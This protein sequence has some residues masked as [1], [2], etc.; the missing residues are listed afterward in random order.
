M[1]QILVSSSYRSMVPSVPEEASERPHAATSAVPLAGMVI[2]LTSA[3][4]ISASLLLS[5]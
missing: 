2:W 5:L 3:L 1:V 4:E